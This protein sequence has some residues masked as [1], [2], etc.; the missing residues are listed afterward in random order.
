MKPEF[1]VIVPAYNEQEVIEESYK[2][3]SAVMKELNEPYELIFIDD[4]S[5][6]NTARILAGICE[7]DKNVKLL[8][9]SRNFGHMP[10]IT[11]GMDYA[12]GSAVLVIDAD[13]QDPPELFPKM[14]EKW[15]EGYDV[16]YGKR[17]ERK[18]ETAFKKLT[19]GMYYRFLRRMT[20][21]DLPVDTGEFRLIDRKVCDVIKHI[22]EKNRYIRGLV[23]WV[24]FKQTA[25]EYVR[26]KRFAGETKYPLGKMIK[27]A[28]NGITAF[29]YKPLKLATHLGLGISALSFL[30]LLIVL[31]QRLF[32]NSTAEGWASMVAIVLF[33][34]GIV[35]IV[36]GLMGE[37]IG[38]IFE[39][40]KDRPIYII[41]EILNS[42]QVSD[43]EG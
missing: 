38:R 6:D 5:R 32:T 29:S 13:L 19:A 33:S 30:Y 41:D 12:R 10:A 1:S 16:V 18:G 35:L 39:E 2:R 8:R 40:I 42:E 25:V 27:L 14:I 4:G 31:Y 37:Y 9:F 15:R 21:V 3:L 28:M 34:Q 17:S 7:E 26:E 11:A 36:L 23:S 24:G 22:K 43:N 20:D